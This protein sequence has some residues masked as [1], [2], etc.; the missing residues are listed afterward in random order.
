MEDSSQSRD[1]AGSGDERAIPPPSAKDDSRK[2]KRLTKRP[3]E[4]ENSPTA[5]RRRSHSRRKS[6]AQLVPPTTQKDTAEPGTPA[7]A[8][9]T[10]S[11]TPSTT[12]ST[13][14]LADLDLSEDEDIVFDSKFEQK[15]QTLVA[16]R[17]PNLP[18]WIPRQE[19]WPEAF[20]DKYLD[21]FASRSTSDEI[22]QIRRGLGRQKVMVWVTAMGTLMPKG[23]ETLCR[24]AVNHLVPEGLKEAHVDKGSVWIL[25]AMTSGDG[26]QKL[27]ATQ[28]L[29]HRPHA[30][31]VFFRKPEWKPAT[32][33]RITTTVPVAD[34][35][36]PILKDKIMETL[37]EDVPRVLDITD[38][39]RGSNGKVSFKALLT[40]EGALDWT[41]LLG[42]ITIAPNEVINIRD[43]F[44]CAICHSTDHGHFDCKWTTLKVKE[45]LKGWNLFYG[46]TNT[47]GKQAGGGKG[48]G[49]PLAVGPSSK[50][51]APTRG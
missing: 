29:V 27:I 30:V 39:Y 41:T 37:N 10:T 25:V 34:Y 47:Q 45:V 1:R 19:T 43:S 42:P 32:D 3:R 4:D 18:V 22:N 28:A 14:P 20:Y 48:R 26:A 6:Q 24:E 44:H 13:L 7:Q 40:E 50:G 12:E 35:Q 5:D 11:V 8:T 33:V 49:K 9:P 23:K 38:W 17:N 36:L 2:K 31:V 51:A 21:G 16:A 15:D 46:G